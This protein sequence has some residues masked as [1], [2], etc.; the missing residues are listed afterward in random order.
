MLARLDSYDLWLK[1][2]LN[3]YFYFHFISTFGEVRKN[4][5]ELYT[6][7]LSY[8]HKYNNWH[9]QIEAEKVK[10]DYPRF[11]WLYTPLPCNKN[12]KRKRHTAVQWSVSALVKVQ[13]PIFKL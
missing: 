13:K 11:I 4:A 5:F 12:A 6:D 9:N 8:S 10:E 2:K 3:F 1:L 7:F